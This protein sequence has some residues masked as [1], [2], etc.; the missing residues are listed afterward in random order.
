MA[1]YTRLEM[2]VLAPLVLIAP[3]LPTKWRFAG[4][5]LLAA[6]AVH[7]IW[8]LTLTTTLARVERVETVFSAQHIFGNLSANLQYLFNPSSFPIAASAFSILALSIRQPFQKWLIAWVAAVGSVHLGFYAGSFAVNPRYCIQIAIP[9]IALAASLSSRNIVLASIVITSLFA[10]IRSWS[11]PSS[12]QALTAEHQRALEFA[13]QIDSE[14]RVITSE[15]EVFMNS[16]KNAMNS[17]FATEPTSRIRAQFGMYK[18][19]FY[20]ESIR[21]NHVGSPEWAADQ[22]IKSEFKLDVVHSQNRNGFRAVVYELQQEAKPSFPR[23]S[24]P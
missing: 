13:R 14:D 17:V 10:A 9:I 1:A 11:D 3:R 19:I 21:T 16:G 8:V 20:Y 6:E 24:P 2:I 22:R 5:C 18:R 15:P 4:L 12:V 23:N 7:L